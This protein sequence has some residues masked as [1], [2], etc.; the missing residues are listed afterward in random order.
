MNIKSYFPIKKTLKTNTYKLHWNS[1]FKF[2]FISYIQLMETYLTSCV[3]WAK[4]YFIA[5][6]CLTLYTQISSD[7]R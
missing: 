3:L 2:S 5:V 6:F 4:T 1:T 7:I